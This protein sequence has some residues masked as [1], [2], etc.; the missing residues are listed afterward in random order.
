[1]GEKEI[2]F[3]ERLLTCNLITFINNFLSYLHSNKEKIFYLKTSFLFA[4][5]PYAIVSLKSTFIN[6]DIIAPL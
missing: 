4:W 5:T 6:S 2:K 3:K 1:M